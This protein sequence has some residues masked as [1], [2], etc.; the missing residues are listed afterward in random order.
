MKSG[1]I[2]R[3]VSLNTHRLTEWDFRCDVKLL[4]WRP[5]RHFTKKSAAIWWLHTQRLHS[6]YVAASAICP[7]ALLYS[8]WSIR[9]CLFR[10]I[11]FNI[12]ITYIHT[13]DPGAVEFRRLTASNFLGVEVVDWP[14]TPPSD[15][16]R[17]V[18]VVFNVQFFDAITKSVL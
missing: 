9:T 10:N 6:A 7:Q 16:F 8:S 3:Q 12:I 14:V 5:W 18:A 13:L 1:R 4:R 17:A 11:K 15:F 2:V